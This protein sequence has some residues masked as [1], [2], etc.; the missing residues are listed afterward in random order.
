MHVMIHG[1]RGPALVACIR[2]WLLQ[3]IDAAAASAGAATSASSAADECSAMHEPHACADA[4]VAET[5]C[6]GSDGVA[7]C[8]TE[9]A[10]TTA[11]AAVSHGQVPS[12]PPEAERADAEESAFPGCSVLESTATATA[13]AATAAVPAA[14]PRA[15]LPRHAYGH[16][17]D[18]QS[19][20]NTGRDSCEMQVWA[21]LGTRHALCASA[22]LGRNALFVKSIYYKFPVADCL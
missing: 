15:C 9:T 7:P 2:N 19:E 21:A 22:E 8:A 20:S 4:S 16:Q 11:Q 14:Q 17:D 10:H 1:R 12:N 18:V 6:I 5:P 3:Q 13:A